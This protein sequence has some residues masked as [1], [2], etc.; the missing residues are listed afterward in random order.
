MAQQYDLEAWFPGYNAFRE[1][2]SCSNCTDYQSR[3]TGT[4]LGTKKLGGKKGQKHSKR[5]YVHM[6]NSTLVACTRT[7]C[8]ILENYQGTRDQEIPA[9]T[10]AD[11]KVVREARTVKQQGVHVPEVLRDYVGTDFLPFVRKARK[12]AKPTKKKSG[13]KAAAKKAAA[14]KSAKKAAP[15][16]AA[17][18]AGPAV[19]SAAELDTLLATKSYVNGA[20]VGKTCCTFVCSVRSKYIMT[21]TQKN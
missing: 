5:E 17:A 13:K 4:R 9:K 1:L 21:P 16:A 19:P 6:L 2:V 12:V 14:K 20:F 15:A 3:A 18:S 7:L 10:D 11:G 8:C